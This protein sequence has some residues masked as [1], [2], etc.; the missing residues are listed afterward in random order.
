MIKKKIIL[1]KKSGMNL[2][3][4]DDDRDLALADYEN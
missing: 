2:S 4:V 1:T 3:S